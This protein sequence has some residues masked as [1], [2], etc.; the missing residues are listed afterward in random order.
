MFDEDPLY[1]YEYDEY[2]YDMYE[3]EEPEHDE[4]CKHEPVP[5]KCVVAIV[6]TEDTA[7][8]LAMEQM[9]N[10]SLRAY[11]IEKVT[12]P[13][14]WR[15]FYWIHPNDGAYS[16]KVLSWDDPDSKPLQDLSDFKEKFYKTSFKSLSSQW[17]HYYMLPNTTNN[18]TIYTNPA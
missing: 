3:D 10:F 18:F 13:L 9:E 16:K 7:L 17:A 2:K 11:D 15:V 6:A 14:G 4:S 12:D 8:A 5:E 1:D